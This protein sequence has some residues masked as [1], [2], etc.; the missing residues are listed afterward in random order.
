MAT[1]T[2]F[3]I[4]AAY[5]ACDL[6]GVYAEEVAK[7]LLAE[8][9][10][11]L[12]RMIIANADAEFTTSQAS[13][14]NHINNMSIGNIS[15]AG[16]NRFSVDLYLNGDLSRPS[17]GS[18]SGAYDIVGLFIHGWSPKSS[19]P[20]RVFGSW[21]GMTVGNRIQKDSMWFLESAISQFNAKYNADGITA[22][23]GGSYG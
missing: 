1:L 5:D 2:D 20:K 21:H 17:L 9:A 10:E 13:V 23:I 6:S 18:G 8:A 3:D 7:E 11:D 12:R 22:E 14:Y 15:R 19:P 16:G 4:S